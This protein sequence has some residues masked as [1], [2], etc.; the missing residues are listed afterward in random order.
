MW[1]NCVSK[2]DSFS[3]PLPEYRATKYERPVIDIKYAQ[4][5]ERG[6]ML[7]MIPIDPKI[8]L[9]DA[10][11]IAK[12]TGRLNLIRAD[13]TRAVGDHVIAVIKIGIQT[14]K[15]PMQSDR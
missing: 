2:V 7:P 15:V 10:G 3:K 1:S 5:L 12:E 11:R 13:I 9:V 6:E 8:S 14:K 4:M